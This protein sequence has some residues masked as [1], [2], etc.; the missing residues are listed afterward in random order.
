LIGQLTTTP[1][2][3]CH[4][5][6]RFDAANCCRDVADVELGYAG[7]DVE[8]FGRCEGITFGGAIRVAG[9]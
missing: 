2:P 3:G 9:S 1:E 4:H 5:R 8:W 6:L 7:M